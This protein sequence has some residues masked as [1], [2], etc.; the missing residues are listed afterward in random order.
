MMS[1]STKAAKTETVPV[2]PTNNGTTCATSLPLPVLIE[3]LN[4]APVELAVSDAGAITVNDANVTSADMAASNGI[5]HVLDMV[6]LPPTAT[7]P[8]AAVAAATTAAPVDPTDAVA[9]DP[10]EAV[11]VRRTPLP[12]GR[13]PPLC[14]RPILPS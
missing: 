8:A 9:V 2:L 6:L 1:A 10:T 7:N 4:G 11:P 3:T 5:V 12:S 13:S 14:H